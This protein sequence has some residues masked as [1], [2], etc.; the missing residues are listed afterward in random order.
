VAFRGTASGLGP[1]PGQVTLSRRQWSDGTGGPQ[2]LGYRFTAQAVCTRGP[3]QHHHPPGIAAADSEMSLERTK[4]WATPSLTLTLTIRS[5]SAVFLHL[6]ML[7]ELLHDALRSHAVTGANSERV[8]RRPNVNRSTLRHCVSARSP[9][10]F[11]LAN[12][13]WMLPNVTCVTLSHPVGTYRSAPRRLN[14]TTVFVLPC[15]VHLRL[16]CFT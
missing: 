9:W 1:R 11:C 8:Q 5:V 16:I 13:I 14:S 15:Y 10:G 3:K 7:T 12:D 6:Y 2:Q 4:S